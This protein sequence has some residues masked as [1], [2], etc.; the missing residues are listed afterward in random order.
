M[1]FIPQDVAIFIGVIPETM[2]ALVKRFGKKDPI[3]F[4]NKN[5]TKRLAAIAKLIF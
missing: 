3:E 5:C 1:I 2:A 4:K